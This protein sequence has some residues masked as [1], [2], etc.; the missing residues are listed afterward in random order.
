MGFLHAAYGVY[1]FFTFIVP[2]T[3]YQRSLKINTGVGALSAPLVAT[4]FSYLRHWS[5][6][7]LVSLA[8]A[9]LNVVILFIVFGLKT[10]DGEL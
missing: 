6:H 10:Q 4:Q 7:Y 9:I 3:A 2:F 1:Y 8:I 5:F